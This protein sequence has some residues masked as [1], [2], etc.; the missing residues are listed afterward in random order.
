MPMRAGSYRCLGLWLASW[1]CLFV[2]DTGRNVSAEEPET[3]HR[4]AIAENIV[5][6]SDKEIPPD[7][8]IAF[9]LQATTEQLRDDVLL[10]FE[11]IIP[12]AK[13]AGYS[14]TARIAVNDTTLDD[15]HFPVNWAGQRTWSLPAIRP[16]PLALYTPGPQ[17]WTVRYDCDR[18]PPLEGAFY[19]SPEMATRFV[20]MFPICKLLREG[21]NQVEIENVSR[22]YKL[23]LLS[24]A[25]SK[26]KSQ[27]TNL[28]A[29]RVTDTSI[30]LAWSCDRLRC[31]IDYRPVGKPAWETVVN[32]SSWENPYNVITLT[33]ATKYECRVRAMPQP[34]AD[35]EGKVTTAKAV[36]SSVITVQTNNEPDGR[37]FAELRLRPTRLI[38]GGLRTYPCIESHGGLLWL[39][40]G[41]LNLI[42]LDPN[43]GKLIF[44]S[45]KPLANWPIDSPRG[46]MGIPDT[47]VLDH[48]LWVTYNIQATRNPDGYTINQSRQFLLSYDFA[49]GEVS[50]PVVVEPL[51]SDY[52]SWEGGV[53]VW[54][55]ELWVMHMDVWKQGELRRTRIVL[56]TFADGRFGQPIVYEN[57]PTVYPYGPSISVFDDKLILLFS[58][59]AACE[60]DP[61]R[62]PLLYTIFDGERFSEAHTVQD[63]GRNRYAKG[64]QVGDRF[65]CAYKCSAPYYETFGYDY[66]D[67]ALSVFTPGSDAEV[68]TTMYVDDRKYN[69]SPDVTLHDDRVFVV[70]NKYEHLY[71]RH[72]NPA[73]F[74]GDFIGTLV[75]SEKEPQKTD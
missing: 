53:E 25:T 15:R 70:Y 75:P 42:K 8:K 65:L 14:P 16:D 20:Y 67:I 49:T 72:D 63:V 27:V 22:Q 11:A 44:K 60:D 37:S 47:T 43:T 61:N 71:G 33:P 34:A 10:R 18:W 17:A 73:V 30:E 4:L 64:V 2:V 40:D 29:V 59:L 38:P 48:K 1:C 55:G 7:G 45:P 74:H 66:H 35:L 32:V 9:L 58:D 54:R 24:C 41:S 12:F 46:Y 62:E 39:V 57:C 5:E 21:E 6:L 23:L 56:R 28:R 51:E 68:Q 52:G 3:Q 13:E 26:G 50:K 36:E 19:Y 69:S 31:E